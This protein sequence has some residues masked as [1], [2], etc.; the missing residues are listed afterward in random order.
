MAKAP[1][2]I[3]GLDDF[4]LTHAQLSRLG[5]R[6]V[7][8]SVQLA[9]ERLSKLWHLRPKTR[10]TALRATLLKQLERLQRAFPT[11]DFVSR[12]KGKPS[13][14]IDAVVPAHTVVALASRR[15]VNYVM[16]D[17]I[18]GRQKRLRPAG[19]GWFCVWGVVAIQLEG[20]TR[21]SVDVEDRLV[22]VKATDADD[23]QRRL[24]RMWTTYSRPYLNPDGHLVRW[25]LMS[26]RDVFEL[27]DNKIDP[28][29]TEVYS[30]LRRMRM[31]PEFLWHPTEGR[32]ATLTPKRR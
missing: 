24:A 11:I 2:R 23:A 8:L 21:G 20:Q 25:Q 26:I 4:H 30:R 7:R 12:G 14:M 17:T 5:Q 15:E 13:W 29:G 18:E 28:R 31:R 32:T 6:A 22:L 10:D 27:F 1:P 9:G 3:I 16:V 19:L